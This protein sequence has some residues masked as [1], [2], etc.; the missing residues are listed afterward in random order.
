MNQIELRIYMLFLSILTEWDEFKELDFQRIYD[1]MQKPAFVFDGR[2]MSKSLKPVA[3]SFI[4]RPAPPLRQRLA[5]ARLRLAPGGTVARWVL[6]DL[7]V[8]V[9][10]YRFRAAMAGLVVSLRLHDGDSGVTGVNCRSRGLRFS[11]RA[12]RSFVRPRLRLLDCVGEGVRRGPLG[13][14]L[15]VLCDFM[16][17]LWVY[18]P[19]GSILGSSRRCPPTQGLKP[20]VLLKSPRYVFIASLCLSA[21]S[22]I[23]ACLTLTDLYLL[24]ILVLDRCI[25]RIRPPLSRRIKYLSYFILVARPGSVAAMNAAIRAI[26]SATGW[27]G[28]CVLNPVSGTSP[29]DAAEQL[30]LLTR[31][32]SVRSDRDHNSSAAGTTKSNYRWAALRAPIALSY[33]ALVNDG[34][35]WF[36]IFQLSWLISDLDPVKNQLLCWFNRSIGRKYD[37][38]AHGLSERVGGGEGL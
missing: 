35:A 32:I 20:A 27:L 38:A 16:Y 36:G 17:F 21:T 15:C 19:A 5:P 30:A 1:N 10:F 29:S 8:W 31:T 25:S 14:G 22:S 9:D 4:F 28:G 13:V 23:P 37:T 24:L 11:A 12:V 18:S 7:L 2:N 33:E 3:S 34:L 6:A 26:T